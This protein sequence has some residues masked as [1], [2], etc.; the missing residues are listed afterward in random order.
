MAA[1]KRILLL[2]LLLQVRPF[3]CRCC[4]CRRWRRK[5]VHA[6]QHL[7]HDAALHL[8]LGGFALRCDGIDFVNEDD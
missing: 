4:Y 1:L 5:V 8:T 3:F 6:R 2:L 7:R